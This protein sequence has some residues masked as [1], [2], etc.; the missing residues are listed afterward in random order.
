M[1]ASVARV[2]GLQ[3]QRGSVEQQAAPR[4]ELLPV[5]RAHRVARQLPTAR[6]QLK[7]HARLGQV[8]AHPVVREACPR[9]IQGILLPAKETKITEMTNLYTTD[10]R[11]ENVQKPWTDTHHMLNLVCND[12]KS[13]Q[14]HA[15]F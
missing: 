8:Y 7:A 9:H 13:N 6:A 11:H 5:G 12:C 14:P 3:V 1:G 2:V 4:H 15:A 10:G